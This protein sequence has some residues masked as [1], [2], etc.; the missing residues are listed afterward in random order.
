MVSVCLPSDALPQHLPCYLGFTYLFQQNK[1]RLYTK[2]LHMDITRWS[3]VACY[4]VR[5]TE[6]DM[7]PWDLFKEVA[8]IFI[9]STIVW[10]QVKQQG[11]NTASTINR[12]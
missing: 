10:P 4:R 8:I 3:T 1:I 12:N 7:P 2:T 5:G 6:C 11:G 9:N